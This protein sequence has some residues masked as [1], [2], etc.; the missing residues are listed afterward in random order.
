MKPRSEELRDVFDSPSFPRADVSFLLVRNEG[1]HLSS[2]CEVARELDDMRVCVQSTISGGSSDTL[3][4]RNR[5][6]CSNNALGY[7]NAVSPLE[8]P[9]SRR[10]R[11]ASVDETWKSRLW[12]RIRNCRLFVWLRLISSSIKFT[13]CRAGN[14]AS[15]LTSVTHL[16]WRL[17]STKNMRPQATWRKEDVTKKKLAKSLLNHSVRTMSYVERKE[18][19]SQDVDHNFLG[20]TGFRN[21]CI[22]PTPPH[23]TSM[24]SASNS[25]VI[26]TS[27]SGQLSL[28]PRHRIQD[29]HDN[30]GQT[31]ETADF[32]TNKNPRPTLSRRASS[33]S[34]S[35]SK[36]KQDGESSHTVWVICL[37]EITW[38]RWSR[39][40]WQTEW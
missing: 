39:R 4:A 11:Q 33:C 25:R 26:S 18:D 32:D 3:K 28:W 9:L 36:K 34:T 35:I 24:R 29:R 15:W 40:T 21:L 13:V 38:S 8:H 2:L 23:A 10:R 22:W 31:S 1:S 19:L 6:S 20:T 14:A 37:Q 5:N 30:Q 17:D 7:P 27:N 12:G 16:S